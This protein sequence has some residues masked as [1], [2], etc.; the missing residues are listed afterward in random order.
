MTVII[1]LLDGTCETSELT[2]GHLDTSWAWNKGDR[3][4][5]GRQKAELQH[6]LDMIRDSNTEMTEMD[7]LE[8]LFLYGLVK[9]SALPSGVLLINVGGTLFHIRKAV[10]ERIPYLDSLLRWHGENDIDYRHILID[11]NPYKFQIVL[12]FVEIYGS[13]PATLKTALTDADFFGVQHDV[14]L[15]FLCRKANNDDC[16]MACLYGHR[17]C[18]SCRDEQQCRICLQTLSESKI[19]DW[20]LGQYPAMSA[21]S[22]LLS[23]NAVGIGA[24]NAEHKAFTFNSHQLCKARGKWNLSFLH[25][26]DMV[27]DCW[28]YVDF[29]HS[30]EKFPTD[31]WSL[32]NLVRNIDITMGSSIESI[33]GPTLFALTVI[34]DV[35][36][37]LLEPLNSSSSRL[38]LPVRSHWWNQPGC[39]VP[40]ISR[41]MNVEIGVV[42]DPAWNAA[43]VSLIES[44]WC[45]DIF[46]RHRVASTPQNNIS[47]FHDCSS[48]K[49]KGSTQTF[50][51]RHLLNFSHPTKDLIIIVRPY[52]KV[53]A[54]G[55]GP[56]RLLQLVFHGTVHMSLDGLFSRKVLSRHLYGIND[57]EDLVYFLP[58]DYQAT[59]GCTCNLSRID[60]IQLQLTLL[61][62]EYDIFVIARHLYMMGYFS[63]MAHRM[64]VS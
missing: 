59:P 47:V 17:T 64:W 19:A 33:T 16:S 34:R 10:A 56:L 38:V 49:A 7:Y 2:L 4:Y 53:E 60:R 51:H 12:S 63:G 44:E 20:N 5:I 25:N 62:G 9:S 13:T 28:L 23:L 35:P 6:V 31:L 30:A 54:H 24:H 14:D 55:T 39:K 42:V 58:F 1:E 22:A 21:G 61:A 3:L 36:P 41:I 37:P 15:C 32:C 46:E 40:L 26:C 43:A 8:S 27:G 11:R 18:A 50:V 48:F 57:I 45:L 52:Q 29:S